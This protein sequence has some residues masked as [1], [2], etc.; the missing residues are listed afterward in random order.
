MGAAVGGAVHVS[1]ALGES[2]VENGGGLLT[3]C[4]STWGIRRI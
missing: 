4:R 1:M 3:C 2:E